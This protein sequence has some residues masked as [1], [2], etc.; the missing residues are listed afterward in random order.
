MNMETVL[1]TEALILRPWRADD[2]G[3]LVEGL[4]DIRIAQWLAFVPHPYRRADGMKWLDHCLRLSPDEG[5]RPDC[6]FA[7]ERKLDHAVVGGVSLNAV[8]MER[9]SAG[10]GIWI[11]AAYQRLGYGRQ[12]FAARIRFAFDTLQLL[13]LHNGYFAGNDAS[14]DL[15][16][17]FGYKHSAAAPVRRLCLAD[18]TEKDEILTSLHR[19]DWVRD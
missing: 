12:A 10:G 2:I 5:M 13:E 6:E 4:N 11:N 9:R 15:Q 16:R 14:W 1:E 7:I 3:Q 18:G 8:D 17:R 19:N